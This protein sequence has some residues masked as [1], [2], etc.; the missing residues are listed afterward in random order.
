MALYRVKWEIDIEAASAKK[1]AEEALKIQR[2]PESI[3][4]VFMVGKRTNSFID[5]KGLV[6]KRI[7]LI[8]E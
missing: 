4:T 2:D 6:Y 8:K 5:P 7:D 3:A 1:A